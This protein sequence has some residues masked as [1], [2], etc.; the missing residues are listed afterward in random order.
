MYLLVSFFYIFSSYNLSSTKTG[1][2]GWLGQ[3]LTLLL[4]AL[5][6][7]ICV[8]FFLWWKENIQYWCYYLHISRGW[9]IFCMLDFYLI[10]VKFWISFPLKTKPSSLVICKI[11][12]IHQN[13]HN[14]WTDNAILISF[15]IYNAFNICYMIT[16]S[17]PTVFGLTK[18]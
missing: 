9:V 5:C 13:C 12:T 8:K 11:N 17:T 15:E 2:G 14:F 4:C 16:G 3:L 10:I 1:E 6:S 18:M 7:F